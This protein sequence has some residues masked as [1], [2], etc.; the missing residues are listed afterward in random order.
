MDDLLKYFRLSTD[1]V[2]PVYQQIQDNIIQLIDHNVLNTGDALP[3]E[4]QLSDVYGVNRMTVR[5]AVGGLVQK[6]LIERKRG[7]GSFIARRRSVRELTPT[8]IGFSQRMREA[9]AKPSSRLLHREVIMPEPITAHRLHLEVGS[10]I[11]ILK[12]LRLVDG[13]PL[14]IETS[15][16]SYAMFPRL[17]DADLENESLYRIL[18]HDYGMVVE[19]AEHTMEPTLPNAY[20]A[21]H[22]GIEMTMPAM[23]V[24]VLAYSSDRV[25]LELS[26]SIVRADR[27]RYFFRVHTRVPIMQ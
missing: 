13:E 6:G 22:L 2:H 1:S 16:L 14:M 23:L 11:I 3:S 19:E 7:A 21:L 5:Q 24:R 8:V 17:M 18:E 4:R 27:C 20:E 15:Y 10:P 26:K 9:G 25:P 12:R